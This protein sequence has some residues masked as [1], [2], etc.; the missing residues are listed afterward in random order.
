MTLKTNDKPLLAELI[1]NHG[2]MK[3]KSKNPAIEAALRNAEE[4]LDN[5]NP[6]CLP[7]WGRIVYTQAYTQGPVRLGFGK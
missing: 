4:T 6:Q 3:L 5:S 7:V 1:E 2:L